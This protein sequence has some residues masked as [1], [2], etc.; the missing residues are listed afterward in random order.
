MASSR[1]VRIYGKQ[2][3]ELDIALMVQVLIMLGR[4]LHQRQQEEAGSQAAAGSGQPAA[5]GIA[6]VADMEAEA[7]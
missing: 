1:K 2:R 5:P 3:R 4:E 6:E 7:S